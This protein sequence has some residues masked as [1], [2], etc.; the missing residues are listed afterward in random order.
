MEYDDHGFADFPEQSNRSNEHR[1]QQYPADPNKQNGPSRVVW[2]ISDVIDQMAQETAPTAPH[3]DV[4][5]DSQEYI[6]AHQSPRFADKF[7]DSKHGGRAET[8]YNNAAYS[9]LVDSALPSSRRARAHSRSMA[10][11]KPQSD[12]DLQY[13][14]PYMCWKQTH[15]TAAETRQPLRLTEE[16][17]DRVSERLSTHHRDLLFQIQ[18][19]RNEKIAAEL[20]GLTFKPNLKF[21]KSINEKYANVPK[22]QQR[23]TDIVS[24]T[25]EKNIQSKDLQ[26]ARELSECTFEPDL[27]KSRKYR[28][29]LYK[30]KDSVPAHIRCTRYGKEKALKAERRRNLLQQLQEKEFSF[31]PRINSKSR[32]LV[33]ANPSKLISTMVAK[34]KVPKKFKATNTR[35]DPGHEDDT[36]QPN[37]TKRSK[38]VAGESDVY[39]RLYD[40][41][42]K[43]RQ[44]KAEM[45]ANSETLYVHPLEATARFGTLGGGGAD[46]KRGPF[47]PDRRTPG[48]KFGAPA[49]TGKNLHASEFSGG[50][51]KYHSPAAPGPRWTIQVDPEPY[52]N[53]L[54]WGEDMDFIAA[55]FKE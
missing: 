2:R 6:D 50:G 8:K 34:G 37:T 48:K 16:E 44:K 13:P 9:S 54:T 32:R 52:V 22:L 11:D 5:S 14:T 25:R 28:P 49:S 38:R 18:Q 41:A 3:A 36:F 40:A 45:T 51:G 31:K 43:T 46:Y 30:L 33:D 47:S 53:V 55:R 39:T 21:T 10:E 29:N 20:R 12:T 27:S 24:R 26:M 19:A 42:L 23:Y 17:R 15:R 4:V 1:D 35:A 7:P